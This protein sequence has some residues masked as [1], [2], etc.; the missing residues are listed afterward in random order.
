MATNN[1]LIPINIKD[2]PKLDILSNS[3]LIPIETV[4]GT[5]TIL[6]RD[7]II[8]ED[9][10]TFA[11]TLSASVTSAINLSA[12]IDTTNATV[13][14]VSASLYS[15]ITALSSSSFAYSNTLSSSIVSLNATVT[16]LSANVNTLS[17]SAA[18][19]ASNIVSLSSAVSSLRSTIIA[20]TGSQPVHYVNTNASLSSG[21]GLT[22]IFGDTGVLLANSSFYRLQCSLIYFKNLA[23]AVTFSISSSN[24]ITRLTGKIIHSRF[25]DSDTLYGSTSGATI[26]GGT[27]STF[28]FP[29]TYALN[30]YEHQFADI[31]VVIQTNLSSSVI[32]N[33]N[34]SVGSISPTVGSRYTATKLN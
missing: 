12:A 1:N 22:S 19:N 3:D 11:A 21:S 2:L 30:A 5:A 24:T 10:I 15:S 17:L 6:Y 32:L 9:H 34:A 29:A 33:V 25:T 14:T 20:V 13:K 18:T 31:D 23:G 7:F 16:A 26:D 28:S 4:E 27:V 8:D